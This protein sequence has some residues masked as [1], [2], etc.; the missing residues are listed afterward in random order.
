MLH[1]NEALAHAR[2]SIA[3]VDRRNMDDSLR[4]AKERSRLND[5]AI[6][7]RTAEDRAEALW[8][9]ANQIPLSCTM[10]KLDPT[11]VPWMAEGGSRS[12]SVGS[13]SHR[14]SIDRPI[15]GQQRA[16]SQMSQMEAPRV[17]SRPSQS[18]GESRGGSRQ[19]A[20][21]QTPTG[22]EAE[23]Y[24]LDTFEEGAQTL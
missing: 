17:Q 11:L 24:S 10:D 16:Q 12:R 14:S 22:F 6:T 18:R 20:R 2:Q 3:Q 13:R 19:S 4:R 23:P 21:M 7:R 9:L 15:S 1:R 5:L 8:R